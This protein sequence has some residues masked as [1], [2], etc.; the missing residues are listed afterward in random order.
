M[1]DNFQGC[2]SNAG[3]QAESLCSCSVK[4]GS[5]MPV[6]RVHCNEFFKPQNISMQAGWVSLMAN[7]RVLVN[8]QKKFAG[9]VTIIL[10]I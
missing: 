8:K 4:R 6:K 10:G 3:H 5:S 7:F 9:G 2:C 1:R